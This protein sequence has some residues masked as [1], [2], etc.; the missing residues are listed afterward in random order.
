MAENVRM[1]SP[2]RVT[3]LMPV[4][5]GE[6]YV[7]SAIESVLNQTFADFQF[8]IVDDSSTDRSADIIDAYR[9]K[10]PRIIV[11][12]NK[13]E[14]GIVGALNTGIEE[15][16]GEYI[17]RMDQ[18]DVS[19]P[20]RMEKQVRFMDK[21]PDV[22]A[23]GTWMKTLGQT[24]S[25]LWLP[26]PTDHEH[27]KIALLFYTSLAHPTVIM[28]RSFLEKHELRYEERFKN[29]EDYDLWERCALLFQLANIPEALL[30]YRLH[31]ASMSRTLSSEQAELATKV[32]ARQLGRLGI[33][34]TDDELTI[35]SRVVFGPFGEGDFANAA[36]AWLL[37]LVRAN[38][39]IRLYDPI[40]FER[41]MQRI[42]FNICLNHG[43]VLEMHRQIAE[44]DKQL[45][46]RDRYIEALLAS[47]SWRI[48]MP[49]RKLWHTVKTEPKGSN[50]E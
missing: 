5:N 18:D 31:A 43:Q 48:T 23:S 9:L 38:C 16:R 33:V 22:G 42:H 1:S 27:I 30:L 35:H 20:E 21:H 28:R 49:L 11:A 32:V 10:D 12:S 39:S 17:A 47:W 50:N 46:E 14:K 6:K 40:L 15:A 44:R 7:G 29:A 3:V 24:E 13:K 36:E 37:K 19:L 41:E 45:E 4:Y 26:Y 8:L 25:R 34:P 2:P